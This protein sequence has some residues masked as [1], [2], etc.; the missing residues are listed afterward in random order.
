[1]VTA[2]SLSFL[3]GSLVGVNYTIK[4]QFFSD[5]PIVKKPRYQQ[6]QSP[7]RGA[8]NRAED[9]EDDRRRH[10]ADALHVDADY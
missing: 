9:G 10:G 4:F 6:K 1:M 3:S 8:H 2:V 7:R 5:Y